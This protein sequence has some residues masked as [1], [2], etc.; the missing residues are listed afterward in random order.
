MNIT[1]FIAQL[2][3]NRD[4]SSTFPSIDD[5]MEETSALETQRRMQ[6]ERRSKRITKTRKRKQAEP[7]RGYL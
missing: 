4:V 1:H 7:P 6:F 3:L 5:E 2:T